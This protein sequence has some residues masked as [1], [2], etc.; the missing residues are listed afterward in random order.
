MELFVC[1]SI[2]CPRTG[3][4]GEILSIRKPMEPKQTSVADGIFDY[5]VLKE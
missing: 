4:G 3:Q 1:F 5:Q 2:F